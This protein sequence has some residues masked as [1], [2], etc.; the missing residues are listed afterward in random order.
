MCALLEMLPQ[1]KMEMEKELT[2]G[3]VLWTKYFFETPAK[4]EFSILLKK[5]KK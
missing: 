2:Q 3:M 5:S 4:I 1:L